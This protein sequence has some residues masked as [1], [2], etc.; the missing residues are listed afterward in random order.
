M[1]YSGPGTSPQVTA[2][3]DSPNV[4]RFFE[5]FKQVFDAVIPETECRFFEVYQSPSDPELHRQNGV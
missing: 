4:P 1:S 3:I 2:H 5:L